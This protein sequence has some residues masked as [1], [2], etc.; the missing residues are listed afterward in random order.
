[1]HISLQDLFAHR[2]YTN[3]P[4]YYYLDR[5]T[6]KICAV[7]S[8]KHQNLPYIRYIPLPQVDEEYIQQ[9]YLQQFMGKGALSKFYESTFCFE[10]LMHRC[11]EWNSWWRFYE[12]TVFEIARQWCTENNIVFKE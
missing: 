6:Y 12:K 8:L 11:N 2:Q 5:K 4:V 10:E 7:N 9:Q 3:H 1:M